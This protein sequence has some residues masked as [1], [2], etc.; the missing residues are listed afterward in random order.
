MKVIVTGASGYIGQELVKQLVDLQ[1][2]VSALSRSTVPQEYVCM[3]SAV[4]GTLRDHLRNADAVVHLAGQLVRD[5][6]APV[7]DYL[8]A[9]VVFTDAVMRAAIDEHVAVVVH[10]SSRL[11]YPSTLTE[12]ASEC[13]ARP[14]TPYGLSKLW[15]EDVVRYHCEKSRVAG[16]SLRIGQVTG[17]KHPGLGAINSFIRQAADHGIIRV[18]GA[19]NAVRD[20][21]HVKDVVYAF[22]K[23]LDYRGPWRALNLG[24]PAPVTI[25]EMAETVAH[26][27]GPQVSV[28]HDVV[29]HED[30][31][32]YALRQEEARHVLGWEPV[33]GIADII[34]EAWRD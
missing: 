15:A 24:G 31:S 17:G 12:A 7:S 10:A 1:Y 20:V 21:V 13:D 27:A 22:L 16:L 29:E 6:L 9:N 11:V 19:G 34:S 32:C 4:Q 8:D 25:R 3:Q 33:E 14:D 23:A 30:T 18:A 26:I 2:S 28:I 5:P